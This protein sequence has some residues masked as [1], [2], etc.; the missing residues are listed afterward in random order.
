MK[1]SI[2]L[3]KVIVIKAIVAL[4]IYQF[5]LGNPTNFRNGEVRTVPTIFSVPSTREASWCRS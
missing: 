1:Q 4:V 3:T 2:F 5:I